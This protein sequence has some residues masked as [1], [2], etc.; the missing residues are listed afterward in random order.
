MISEQNATRTQ[1]PTDG[2]YGKHITQ[3]C[4]ASTDYRESTWHYNL[5]TCALFA[6]VN[7]T[8]FPQLT[9]P[10]ANNSLSKIQLLGRHL[11]QTVTSVLWSCLQLKLILF[12]YPIIYLRSVPCVRNLVYVRRIV[13]VYSMAAFGYL[14]QSLL[15]R[16]CR[17]VPTWCNN[18]DLLS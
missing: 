18:Y 2:A 9:N 5:R 13:R 8:P 14:P 16:K 17:E 12:N 4:S 7:F 10:Y 11:A 15:Y 6:S 1:Q 3:N